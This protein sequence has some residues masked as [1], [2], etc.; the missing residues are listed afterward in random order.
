MS[1]IPAMGFKR[2]SQNNCSNLN[3]ASC[4]SQGVEKSLDTARKG[5]CATSV[6]HCALLIMLA[7]SALAQ[8]PAISVRIETVSGRTQFRMGEAITLKLT[9]DNPSQ[10]RRV[11]YG[12]EGG[13]RGVLGLMSDRFLVSPREGTTDPWS[14][15]LRECCV[16][17]GPGGMGLGAKQTVTNVDLNEW[18]RFDGA[19]RY[20]VSALFHTGAMLPA[21]P[22][23][24][25]G[26]INS[27][28]IEIE[29]IP[30]SP[31]WLGE[32]LRQAV[33]VLDAPAGTGPQAPEAWG[34]A[35]R[36]LCYLDTPESVRE[37]A[38]LLG[39]L[40]D[41]A[42]W[43]QTAV[44]G[45]EHQAVA[46]AA[47]QQLLRLPDQAVTPTFIQTLAL[48]EAAQQFPPPRDSSAADP[49]GRRRYE[50][51]TVTGQQLSSEL[52]GVIA[53][54]RGAAKA[55][56]LD[57]VI[58]GMR[59]ESIT[60]NL[61][62]ELAAVFVDLPWQQQSALLSGQWK[63]IASP[64]MIPVLRQIYENPTNGGL[65]ALA[66]RR[67]YELD[68]A[69]TRTVILDDMKR[70]MPELPF[71]TL[72]ILHDATLPE[73]DDVL[74]DHLQRGTGL[75]ELIARYATAKILDG[76]KEWY[77]KRDAMLR[78]RRSPSQF[79]IA[80]SLCQP[81]LIGYYLRVDP[82][83][84]ERVLRSVLNDRSANPRGGCWAGIVGE[85]A[86]YQAG[87]AWEK[88]AIEALTDPVVPVKS[89][90]VKALGQ[91]GSP[92]A[93]QAV[94]EA[95][96]YWHGWWKDKPAEMVGERP[97][98]QAFLQAAARAQNWIAT[99]EDM[100]KVRELCITIGCRSNAEDYIRMWEGTLPVSIGESGGGDVSISFAQYYERSLD[101]ARAR[102]MQVPAGTRLKWSINGR[103]PEID[104]WVAAINSD[105][106]ARGVVIT[107]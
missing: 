51:S 74:L 97:F 65:Q 8:A 69:R 54:K 26:A 68:P 62:A 60:A 81:A 5:A 31:E 44:R 35:Q 36:T 40:D 52:A 103:S 47:M 3:V 2:S 18:V 67:A 79:D 25:P 88:V 83:W 93:Q 38:R 48:M 17:S 23:Q 80:S 46:I 45:S 104:A 30:A 78:A 99:G 77:A 1:T 34:A 24:Q 105:L 6:G 82:A 28:Q 59:F 56:S 19:G 75:V 32:Q 73:M 27:N 37:A 57:T 14:F 33:A 42:R 22:E 9:F 13:G 71:E 55:I 84:G 61:R 21:I 86:Q 29:I 107:P 20:R 49:D 90:A 7:G 95:F 102:L 101:A 15:R 63:R 72:A 58:G 89:D 91:Y 94:M 11:I 100:E 16:Y 64:A 66:V 76:V 98:E 106:A 85:T 50:A 87:P 92:A 10:E 41:Q 4:W 70:D 43:L 53:R 39:V 12:I 96:R